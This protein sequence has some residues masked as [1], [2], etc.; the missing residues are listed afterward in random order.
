M[1]MWGVRGGR[2]VC[3]ECEGREVCVWS[4]KRGWG[5]EGRE[6]CVWSVKGGWEWGCEEE[7][8]ILL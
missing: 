3:V 7:G 1:G 4:V 8:I 5:C 2:C 6:V